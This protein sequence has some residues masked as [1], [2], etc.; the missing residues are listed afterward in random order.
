MELGNF[1]YQSRV[2]KPQLKFGRKLK[3]EEKPDYE[4]TI[5][6]SFDYLGIQNRALILHGSSFP[7]SINRNFSKGNSKR[8]IV[9]PRN[10][11]VGSPYFSTKFNDFMKMNGFNAIQLGPNGKLNKG[12][13]SPYAA[14]V[15]AKNENFLVYDKLKEDDYANIIKD[16][17]LKGL[18]PIIQKTNNNYDKSDF[19]EAREVAG[20]VTGRAYK[21]FETKINSGDEK[22]Q[23]LNKE[24]VAFKKENKS[25]LEKD[26]IFRILSD[27]HG[28]DDFNKWDSEIDKNLIERKEAEDDDA[29]A[30]YDKI[31]SRSERK[32]DKYMFAQFLVDRQEKEDAIERKDS[33]IKFIGDLLVG[34]SRA[35]EWAHPNA[36]VKDW[37][38]GA[39]YGGAGNSQQLWNLPLINPKKLFNEDGSL[40]ESGKLLKE[41]IA[42]TSKHVENLRIDNAMGLV[43]PYVYRPSTIQMEDKYVDGAPVKAVSREKLRA[44]YVANLHEIDPDNNYAK[45]LHNIVIPTLKENGVDPKQAVWENLGEQSPTFSKVFYD[46]EKLPGITVA[47]GTRMQNAPKDN[48]SLLSSHDN[49]P[50]AHY[51]R[52]GW[53]FKNDAWNPM[54]LGGYLNPDPARAKEKD[55]FIEEISKN[56]QKRLQAKYAELMRGTKNIQVSFVDFFGIDKIYNC[57]GTTNKDNWKLRLNSNYEDTYHKSLESESDPA[58][59]MPQLLGV[60]VNAKASLDVAEGRETDEEVNNEVSDLETSLKKYDEIFKEPEPEV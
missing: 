23:A 50:T 54:Y 40:G 14:S 4:K 32:I 12:D 5:N 7:D 17:D 20:I 18:E 58:M 51:L 43:D 11:Y 44:G 6:Q 53:V 34:F 24:F 56:P 16:E 1:N 13:N 27:I 19:D 35:D 48:W 52:Q 29:S 60:A 45:I 10:P 49:P 2:G 21:N 33:G 41:K 55:K 8:N 39:E 36:F 9:T 3:E 37:E 28:T 31:K 59:N 22:A 46:Q 47:A 38:V 57:P 30:R 15:Y 25:W 42:R 26:S